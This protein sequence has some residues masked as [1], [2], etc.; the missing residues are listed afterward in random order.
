MEKDVLLIIKGIHITNEEADD[1]EVLIP[2]EYYFRDDKHFVCYEEVCE[3]TGEKLKC[4]LKICNNIVEV[5]KP[6]I[7]ASR[8]VFE[9]EMKNYS[10][11]STEVGDLYLSVDTQN[12]YIA[13]SEDDRR[14]DVKINY[15][16]GI[17][18][19][20]VSDCEVSIVISSDMLI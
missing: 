14:I 3:T 5:I 7:N 2:A 10:V 20:K 11:Y 19:E 16:L 12:I 6:G 13:T 15:S 17:N 1:T 4:I 9:K 18:E 8:L